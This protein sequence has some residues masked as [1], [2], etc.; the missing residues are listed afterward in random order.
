MP[1]SVLASTIKAASL[2][3]AGQAATVG[4]ISAKVAALMEGVMKSMIV[5]KVT[6]TITVLLVVGVATLGAGGLISQG[7]TAEPAPPPADK[8]ERG[9]ENRSDLHDRVLELKQQLQQMQ[10]KIA[11][12][13]QE[14]LPQ[15]REQPARRIPD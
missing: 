15:R 5:T 12:L 1:A 4:A 11:K 10:T 9:K 2:F 7:W 6:S 14:T 13:E 3:A 8:R